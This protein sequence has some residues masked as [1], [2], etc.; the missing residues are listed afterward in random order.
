MTA[1][2]RKALYWTLKVASILIACA[3]PLFAVFEK[4]PFWVKKHGVG[5]SVSIGVI[6][7]AIVVLII[8]RRAVFGFIKDRLNLK[9][10]PPLAIWIGLII[11]SYIFIFIGNFMRDVTSICWMG[12]VGCAIG[13]LLTYISERF[14][15]EKAE[16]KEK[17]MTENE[18]A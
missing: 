17:E 14:S 3:F 12:F 18:R 11:V 1:R 7:A 13:S 8:F 2:K 6:L 9:H 10:A 16:E 4:F 5:N 15:V